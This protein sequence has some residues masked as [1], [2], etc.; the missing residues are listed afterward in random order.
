MSEPCSYYLSAQLSPARYEAFLNAAPGQPQVDEVWR[1][2]WASRAMVGRL[3]LPSQIRAYPDKTNR[4]LVAG[5][6]AAPETGSAST[7]DGKVWRLSILQ[8]SE[9]FSE[10]L[11]MLVFAQSLHAYLGAGHRDY[12]L[13]YPFLWGDDPVMSYQA[14]SGSAGQPDPAVRRRKDIPPAVF[15]DAEYHLKRCFTA[16][17]AKGGFAD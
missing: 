5:W 12:A 1:S 4:A 9:N 2:W 10:I 13:V 17:Q 11:P 15:A 16:W 7:Y 8:F 6:L 14:L 3:S